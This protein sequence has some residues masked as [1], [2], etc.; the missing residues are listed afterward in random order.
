MAN[1]FLG[2]T[3]RTLGL[4]ETLHPAIASMF[5][6]GMAL[7]EDYAVEQQIDP[8]SESLLEPTSFST[9]DTT[10]SRSN[11][12]D[13]PSY[14][15][16][17]ATRLRSPSAVTPPTPSPFNEIAFNEI[18]IAKLQS[19]QTITP[20][21]YEADRLTIAQ[22]TAPSTIQLAQRR[23]QSIVEPIISGS[24]QTTIQSTAPSTV[25]LAQ[26][27]VQRKATSGESQLSEFYQTIHPLQSEDA[28][29]YLHSRS[30]SQ[31]SG[32]AFSHSQVWQNSF[33]PSSPDLSGRRDMR[34]NIYISSLA[35]NFQR[36]IAINS[37]KINQ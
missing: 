12:R 13:D 11:P 20:L 5:E 24:I 33:A 36:E 35:P 1:Y 3:Q 14:D 32:E 17:Q 25:Q 28:T 18:D 16:T 10:Q 27:I 4:S 31:M 37:N 26:S 34:K 23:V 8:D 22:P 6:P 29:V 30:T 7:M 2:L 9:L 19:T 21:S 15:R